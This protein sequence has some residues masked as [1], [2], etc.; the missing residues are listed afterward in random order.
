M[1]DRSKPAEA[2]F[3]DLA[4]LAV[5]T[6]IWST[7]WRAI[8]LQLGAVPPLDSVVYRFAL[9]AALLFGWCALSGRSL[10]LS[11]RQ[12]LAVLGQG[13][14]GFSIQYGCVYVAEE[15]VASG[16]MAVIFATAPFA[17]M[18]LFRI[19]LNQ[20]A[21]PLAWAA[22]LLGVSGVATLSLSQIGGSPTAGAAGA[23]VLIGLAGVVSV[24]F[25]NFFAARAQSAGAGLVPSTAWA[26]GYGAAVLAGFRL[27]TGSA[28]AFEISVRYVGALLYLS[29]FG[30]VVA[31]LA[32]YGLARRRGYGLASYIA[33]LTP[34]AAMAI[35]AL[36]EG[37]RWGLGAILGVA[38]VLAGQ[39]LL[40]RRPRS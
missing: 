30:S 34:P 11:R 37:T 12:H 4:S 27:L 36:T 19:L 7:T 20:R 1:S 26:M 21:G 39:L 24:A 32:Y 8:K 25:G 28:W 15:K 17:N 33:A 23:G 18:V 6:V 38:L 13:V 16:V 29:V 31:F 9:A 14:F 2:Q 5:C 35:S 40:M 3:V 22:T 10:V